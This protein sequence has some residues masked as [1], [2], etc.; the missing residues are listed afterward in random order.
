MKAQLQKQTDKLFSCFAHNFNDHVILG[1][2]AAESENEKTVY[3]PNAN[4]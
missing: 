1:S 3:L 2:S 4:N